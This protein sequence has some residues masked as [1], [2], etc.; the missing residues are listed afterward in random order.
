MEG[1]RWHILL[2][3]SNSEWQTHCEALAQGYACYYPMQ[4]GHRRLGRWAQ[5]IARPLFPS[6][7]FIG[8]EAGQSLERIRRLN[9]V[10]D[11]LR[12]AG[13]LVVMPQAQ[14]DRCRGLYDRTF[15]DSFP[16]QRRLLELKVGD[17]VAVP[18]GA[19][20]GV[21]VEIEAIDKGGQISA[22][23][24]SLELKFHSAAVHPGVTSSAGA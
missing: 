11:F 24:G 9:G 7:A 13:A 15:R 20:E 14:L 23:L 16:T 2:L 4:M 12:N 22:S 8:L 19:F 1:L 18:S 3:R 6:Y 10:K 17:W 21:P 5:G